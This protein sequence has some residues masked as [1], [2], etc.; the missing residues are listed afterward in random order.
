VNNKVYAA[1]KVLPFME[2]YRRELRMKE[3]RKK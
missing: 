2:N 3:G 1:T